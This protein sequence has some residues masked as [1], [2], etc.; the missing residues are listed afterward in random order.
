[1]AKITEEMTGI[2]DQAKVVALATATKV[3]KPN[4][5]PVAYKKVFSDDE[6]LLVDIFMGKTEENIKANTKV[7]VS[8]WYRVSGVSKGYQFK[9]NARIE[10]S[11]RAFNEGTRMVKATEPELNPKGAVI[12]KVDSIY[13][14]SPGPDAGKQV[15]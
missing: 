5:V 13:I 12:I 14:I 6:L 1:M 10:I 2:V 11:G 8:A 9:G 7:A 15:G 4:V 3:G